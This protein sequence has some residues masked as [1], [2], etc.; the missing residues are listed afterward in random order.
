M[1]PSRTVVNAE[2]MQWLAANPAEPLTS[3]ITS[4]PDLS[5]LQ[6]LGFEGWRSWFI[7]T[8]RSVIRWVPA[9]GVAIFFQSDVRH[10]GA[11]IDKGFLVMS[12]AHEEK[13]AIVWHKIVC[14]KPP[15]S[16][17]L[18]RASYSHMI[19]VARTHRDAPQRPGP[20]VI[21]D[22]GFMPWPR[23]MGATAC[24]VACRFLRE[25][26]PTQIVVDPF[27][28]QGSVLAVANA[29]GFAAVGIDLSPRRC[30]A[31]LK[32]DF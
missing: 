29:H 22:A 7:E 30:R 12:A 14:R 28:G 13:A 31:A 3:V 24:R 25:E 21:P 4:L 20:D 23:A 10:K 6:E 26:T 16:T 11:W 9:D 18:G 17:A 8:A 32:Q 5:E 2:A 19:C 15:G 27:C 1:E